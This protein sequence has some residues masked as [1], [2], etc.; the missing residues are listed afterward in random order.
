MFS[1][2]LHNVSEAKHNFSSKVLTLE[3]SDESGSDCFLLGLVF[4][5][6]SK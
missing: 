5:N 4:H 6:R 2:F 1:M 3:F